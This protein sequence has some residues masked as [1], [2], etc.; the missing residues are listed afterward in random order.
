LLIQPA[1][2]QRG[3]NHDIR[4]SHLIARICVDDGRE[5]PIKFRSPG[6]AANCSN[7]APVSETE[8]DPRARRGKNTREGRKV[9][10]L[11]A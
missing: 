3:N 11:R 6:P 1:I 4:P 10:F 5:H 8:N 7:S 9:D 2:N